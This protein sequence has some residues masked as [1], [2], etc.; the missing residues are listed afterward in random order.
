MENNC[1]VVRGIWVVVGWVKSGWSIDWTLD[2]VKGIWVVVKGTCVVVKGIWVVVKGIWVV[3]KGIW[4][5]VKGIW[6]VVR[7]IWVVVGWTTSG[8]SM[9]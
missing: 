6:V 3:V 1:W 8:S 4:V 5:V 2:V 7:G 9:A